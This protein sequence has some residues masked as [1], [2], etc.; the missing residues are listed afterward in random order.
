ML[1]LT[2]SEDVKKKKRRWRKDVAVNAWRQMRGTGIRT[3]RL[4]I[5]GRRG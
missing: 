4:K 2:W 1:K 3:K 5:G